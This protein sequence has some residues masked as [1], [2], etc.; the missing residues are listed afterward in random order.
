ML[1]DD[2]PRLAR[3]FPA[4][5]IT[6]FITELADEGQRA[7]LEPM[8]AAAAI[9]ERLDDTVGKDGWSQRLAPIGADG[10]V[11]ELTVAE[12]VKSGVA[13]RAAGRKGDAATRSMAD[14]ALARAAERFGMLPPLR[15]A[16]GASEGLWVD[17]D[18]ESGEL[19]YTPDLHELEAGMDTPGFAPLHGEEPAPSVAAALDSDR[20]DAEPANADP[21]TADPVIADPVIADP[22]NARPDGRQVIDR[23]MDRLRGEGL[24]AEAARLV[25]SFGGYGRDPEEARELYRRLRELLLEKAAPA[26]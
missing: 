26:R 7:R 15:S 19:L 11:C 22:V 4:V 21:G 23:L 12:V 24:G 8:L 6:W 14:A 3:P 20:A 25:M 16:G 5:A 10:L 13:G 9:V 1:R 17:A 2:L 18:P